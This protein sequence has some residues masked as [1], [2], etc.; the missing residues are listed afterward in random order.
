MIRLIVV[1]LAVYGLANA[2]T[3]LKAGQPIRLFFETRELKAQNRWLKG[4]WTFWRVLFKCP[5][6]LSF[7]FGM[8]GSH[9]VL[10]ITHALVAPWW[11]SMVVD[12]LIVCAT[13][14]LLHLV[15]ERL[16]HGL[17]V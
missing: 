5:P 6:C 8:A 11:Q 10:S 9:W 17:D 3:V 15:A 12:G 14:W 1:S 2:I 16:G 7:W 13:S 4:F